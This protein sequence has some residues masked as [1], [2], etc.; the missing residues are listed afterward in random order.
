MFR[1]LLVQS[2]MATRHRGLPARS[3]FLLSSLVPQLGR[4]LV[5]LPSAVLAAPIDA[6]PFIPFLLEAEEPE[7]KPGTPAFY[8]KL[9]I[10][11]CLVLIGGM[12]AGLTLR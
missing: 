2:I 9:A 6:A 5:R 11:L 10:V 4:F 7:T 8:F 3:L 12:L 1:Y